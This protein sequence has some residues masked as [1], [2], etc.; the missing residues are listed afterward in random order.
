M[1]LSFSWR[2]SDFLIIATRK[3]N[4]SLISGGRPS[5]GSLPAKPLKPNRNGNTWGG[6]DCLVGIS[7]LGQGWRKCGNSVGV[8]GSNPLLLLNN[9]MITAFFPAYASIAPQF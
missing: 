9:Q 4:Y 1:C 6:L 8:S 5:E 3:R 7:A 2:S